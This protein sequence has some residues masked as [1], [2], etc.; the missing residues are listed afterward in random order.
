MSD[1]HDIAALE[2]SL[3][4]KAS[5]CTRCGE[6]APHCDIMAP[7]A[8]ML[9][10]DILENVTQEWPDARVAWFVPHCSLCGLCTQSCPHDLDIPG[11]I[12]QAREIMRMRGMLSVEAYRPMWIDYDWNAIS[13]YR[14]SYGIDF[15]DLHRER[16]DI[17]YLPSCSLGNEAP[18]LVASVAQW[19]E[20]STGLAVSVVAKCCGMPLFEMGLIERGRAYED[21]L[22]EELAH[23]GVQTVVLDC[24]NCLGHLEARG[25]ELGIEVRLVYDMLG[26]AGVKAKRAVDEV[27]TI[28]D[29]C[30]ARGTQTGSWV[31]ALLSE[32]VTVEM[33]HHGDCSICCGSGGAV[34]M[35]D[36][37]MRDR[38]AKRRVEEF[39]E[40]GA[41]VCVTYCMSSCST[42]S[43]CAGHGRVRHVLEYV[44]D[45]PV[46]H[47][48]Y[49]ENVERMWTGALGE[50][51]ARR[52]EAAKPLFFSTEE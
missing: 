6:C 20:Q 43:Q 39:D 7:L 9:P 37:V 11:F 8:P 12:E 17:A 41:D 42:L 30:P 34:G 13:L 29:S 49:A 24:P 21:A 25:E 1:T 23:M 22:W 18:E 38:R 50:E 27:L 28:H 36:Y 44:F 26:K 5:M 4:R 19:L 40:T 51:N 52:F 48:R 32:F 10:G 47:K 2:A 35:F 31:R 46:D 14:A 33:Q 3:A 16:A 15:G 45:Q